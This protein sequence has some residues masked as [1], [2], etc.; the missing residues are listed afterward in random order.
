MA[1]PRKLRFELR[2][3]RHAQTKEENKPRKLAE[4]QR[5]TVRMLAAVKAGEPFSPDVKSWVSGQ[6]GKSFRTV[7][8]DDLAKLTQ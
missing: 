2:R 7:T 3:E 6:L 4:R 8:P 1:F 5:R